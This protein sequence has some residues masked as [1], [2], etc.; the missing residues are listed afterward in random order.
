MTRELDAFEALAAAGFS[1]ECEHTTASARWEITNVRHKELGIYVQMI[2]N[3][4]RM[5]DFETEMRSGIVVKAWDSCVEY[6][7]AETAE[8]KAMCDKYGCDTWFNMYDEY[9]YLWWNHK[10]GFE[11]FLRFMDDRAFERLRR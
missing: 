11:G 8:A 3:I 2:T 7:D 6:S 10:T 1:D 9:E 5:Y 4:P